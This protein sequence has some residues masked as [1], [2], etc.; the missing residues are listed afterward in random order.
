MHRDADGAGLIGHGAGDGLADPPGRV[1]GEL[2]ALGVV[3]LLDRADQAQVALLDQVQE[4][5]A[6][7][8]VA[9]GQG[10]HEAQVGFQ[11]VVLGLPAVT[12][13]GPQIALE[14]RGELRF[15]VA[16]CEGLL[17][18]LHA[19]G[20]VEAGL[21]PLGQGDFLLGVEQGDLTDLLE[22]GADRVGGGRQLCVLT[23]LPQGGGLVLIPDG[24]TLV[25]LFLFLVLLFLVG[26]E[27]LFLDGLIELVVHRLEV[28]VLLDDLL[29]EFRL[30]GR[31]A[32]LLGGGLPGGLL[33]HLLGDLL[34]D[35]LGH[36][37]HRCGLLAGIRCAHIHG[38]SHGSRRSHCPGGRLAGDLSG[39]LFRRFLG[40]RL[41]CGG[42]RVALA[43]VRECLT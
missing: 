42:R 5:H 21:D 17:H 38:L 32:R 41:L 18:L 20:G 1:G 15:L 28:R 19:V 25:L 39:R 40:D 30:P 23:G 9:L 22:V 36:L 10:D 2:I 6:A 31:S 7:A 29:I 43:S 12:G 11:Q 4:R 13:D 3:E 16:S 27:L 37:L 14:S 35:L 8:G 26:G 34:G 24:G 33:G